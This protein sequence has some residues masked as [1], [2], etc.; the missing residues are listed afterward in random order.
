M[1]YHMPRLPDFIRW[2]TPE[3]HH[4]EKTTDWH[5][6][7]WIVAASAALVSII[8]GNLVFG[9]L[10][11]IATFA[12]KIS[13]SNPPEMIECEADHEGVRMGNILYPYSSIAGFGIDKESFSFPRLV[14]HSQKTLMTHI[15]IPLENVDTD[16]LSEFLE[17]RIP[18]Q[19]LREPLGHKILE[20]IGF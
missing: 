16:L 5:W 15:I 13:A 12:L 19:A 11:I 6:I 17:R 20:W 3:Y 4:I 2:E 10:I 8:L 9:I 18:N 1:I 14:M 7:V